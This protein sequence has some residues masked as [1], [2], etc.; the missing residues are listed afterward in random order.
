MTIDAFHGFTLAIL[1]LFV[2]KGLVARWGILRRYSI[3][4]SL[5]GGLACALVVFALYYGCLLYTSKEAASLLAPSSS[6]MAATQR[7][8]SEDDETAD[9]R[10][11]LG[12]VARTAR[13]EDDL[14]DVTM[15]R[16]RRHEHRLIL[17]LN[18]GSSSIKFAVFDSCLLYTSW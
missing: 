11:H 14:M 1:L 16:S 6:P 2:G 15:A 17:V 5:V 12:E 13:R 3:P 18:C 10:A 8:K 7:A 4:E 9:N